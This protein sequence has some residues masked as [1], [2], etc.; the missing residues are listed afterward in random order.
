MHFGFQSRLDVIVNGARSGRTRVDDC[1]IGARISN[2]T[3]LTS[4]A[5]LQRAFMQFFGRCFV[6]AYA[7]ISRSS[8]G[9]RTVP[10]AVGLTRARETDVVSAE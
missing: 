3:G 8:N 1:D 7:R 6:L 5:E 2:M 10:E 9:R 4:R